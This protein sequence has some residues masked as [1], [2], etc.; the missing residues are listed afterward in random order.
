METPRCSCTSAIARCLR[1]F[2]SREG[3]PSS[4]GSF[5]SSSAQIE[6]DIPRC[7]LHIVQICMI[8]AYILLATQTNYIPPPMTPKTPKVELATKENHI[9]SP[10]QKTPLPPSNNQRGESH[11]VRG[12]EELGVDAVHGLK[13]LCQP[14]SPKNDPE[15]VSLWGKYFL[16]LRRMPYICVCFRQGLWQTVLDLVWLDFGGSVWYIFHL[17]RYFC[18]FCMLV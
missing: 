1:F 18:L 2:V 8:H 10:P 12:V 16:F 11:L 5:V 3:A 13:L 4:A 15:E 6:G 14:F 7:S 9:R 17:I